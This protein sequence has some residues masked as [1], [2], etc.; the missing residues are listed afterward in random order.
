MQ[1]SNSNKIE[2]PE[3]SVVTVKASMEKETVCERIDTPPENKK[4]LC[5]SAEEDEEESDKNKAE[6]TIQPED[7][8]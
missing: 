4:L 1:S 5:N 7:N 2:D 6:N 3:I 8:E